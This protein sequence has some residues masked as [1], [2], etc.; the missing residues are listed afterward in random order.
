MAALKYELQQQTANDILIDFNPN[1]LGNL[2]VRRPNICQHV[3]TFKAHFP[4]IK[5]DLDLL[6]YKFTALN[7]IVFYIN[8]KSLKNLNLHFPQISMT[9]YCLKL[10]NQED[11]EC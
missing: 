6:Q 4:S 9:N 3:S 10:P 8:I 2:R 5:S 7:P 1:P 11:N